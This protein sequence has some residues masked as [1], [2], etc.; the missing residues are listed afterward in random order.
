MKKQLTIAWLLLICFPSWAYLENYGPFEEHDKPK[1]FPLQKCQMTHPVD[2]NE[3]QNDLDYFFTGKD[4]DCPAVRIRYFSELN[5]TAGWL[6]DITSN[7]VC[8]P[9]VILNN[10]TRFFD[11]FHADLNQDN[12][13]DVIVISWTA[14]CG[15]A[16]CSANVTFF[17]SN[18]EGSYLTKTFHDYEPGPPCFIE[19]SNKKPA[20]I[21]T[22]FIGSD[23][24][25]DGKPHN[26]WVYNVVEF[27]QNQMVLNNGR[28][29]HF[30]KWVWYT[31]KPNRKETTLLTSKQ[32]ETFW[33]QSKD[34]IYFEPN[35]RL[36][37]DFDSII[38][39]SASPSGSN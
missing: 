34:R 9:A 8:E 13:Q 2:P 10:F 18:S 3:S 39:Q 35:K 29:D 19:Q 32:K 1:L 17:L 38:R 25:K 26:Y 37:F 6:T 15:L 4:K 23:Q 36:M 11:V 16:A 27:E 21:N 22:A 12:V 5:F 14:G 24:G 30:P 33:E 20:Y 7:P 31:F 28:N